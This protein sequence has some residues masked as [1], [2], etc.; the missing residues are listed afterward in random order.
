MLEDVLLV[1][2][3]VLEGTVEGQA[4]RQTGWEVAFGKSR[5]SAPGLSHLLQCVCVHGHEHVLRAAYSI[6]T[7]PAVW[8][9]SPVSWLQE[10]SVHLPVQRYLRILHSLQ[11]S[12]WSRHMFV[13]LWKPKRSHR[14]QSCSRSVNFAS[15]F[16][17]HP[18]EYYSLIS[19]IILTHSMLLMR[20]YDGLAR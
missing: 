12:L 7:D 9:R 17:W 6:Q 11:S 16:P 20:S 10:A 19:S 4:E 1:V 3:E 5:H 14:I 13:L 18:L 2:E 8:H 15:C